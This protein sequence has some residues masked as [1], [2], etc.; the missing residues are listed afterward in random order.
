VEKDI[1]AVKAKQGRWGGRVLLI[2]VCGLILAG[3]VWVGL[4]IYGEHL[5]N[6]PAAVHFQKNSASPK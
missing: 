6:E 3:I 2:L 4:E 5:A 1:R